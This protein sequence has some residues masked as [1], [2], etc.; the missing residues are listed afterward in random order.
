MSRHLRFLE[1]T[2][3][4]VPDHVVVITEDGEIEFANEAWVEYGCRNGASVHSWRGFNYLGACE[5]A[6]AEG[7]AM[8]EQAKEAIEAVLREDRVAA[9]M[10]YPCHSPTERQWYRMIVT[11]FRDDERR[12]GVVLHRDITEQK[13]QA[14][15]PQESQM[16]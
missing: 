1:N 12:H 13:E 10:D 5:R 15:R 7:D 3:D 14:Q 11:S 6:A 2:L 8:A 16:G 4:A 9:F